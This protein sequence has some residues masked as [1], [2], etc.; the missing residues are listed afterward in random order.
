MRRIELLTIGGALSSAVRGDNHADEE[1]K[2]QGDYQR[3]FESVVFFGRRHPA[4]RCARR[5]E[6]RGAPR[7]RVGVDDTNRS[8]GEKGRRHLRS[9]LKCAR[10]H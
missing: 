6:M 7:L 8:V 9:V 2:A 1:E 4:P 10:C 5:V 3:R